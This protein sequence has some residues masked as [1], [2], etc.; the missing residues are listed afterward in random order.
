MKNFT[1]IQVDETNIL[2]WQGLILPVCLR[3]HPL[4]AKGNVNLCTE[5]QSAFVTVSWGLVTHPIFFLGLL[6]INFSHWKR[7]RM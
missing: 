2:T 3:H 1:N 5:V 7:N 4:Y 6:F